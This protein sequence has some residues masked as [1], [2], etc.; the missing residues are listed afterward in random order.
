[1]LV[2]RCWGRGRLNGDDERQLFKQYKIFKKKN[3][4][5]TNVKKKNEYTNVQGNLLS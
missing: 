1:M 3:E 4:Y 5:L 2:V